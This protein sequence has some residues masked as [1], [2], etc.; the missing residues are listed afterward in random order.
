MKITVIEKKEIEINEQEV[1]SFVSDW[2]KE[3]IEREKRVLSEDYLKWLSEFVKREEAFDD[4]PNRVEYC[5]K[6]TEDEKEKIHLVSTLFS[7]VSEYYD[8]HGMEYNV[9]EAKFYNQAVTVNLTEDISIEMRIWCGQGSVT[10]VSLI[11]IGTG[12]VDIKT[13]VETYSK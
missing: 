7:I 4:E 1:T 5:E 10:N 2:V 9:L 6:Y 13:I 11:Q 8:K 12:K 3:L